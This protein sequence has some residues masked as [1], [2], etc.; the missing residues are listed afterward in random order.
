MFICKMDVKD[1]VTREEYIFQILIR[2]STILR[3][4][5]LLYLKEQQSRTFAD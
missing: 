5:I 2:I 3:L 1:M 4:P